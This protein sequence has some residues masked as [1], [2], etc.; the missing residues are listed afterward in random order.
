MDPAPPPMTDID[1]EEK[2][3]SFSSLE[4]HVQ[5]LLIVVGVVGLVVGLIGGFVA[6]FRV[7]QNLVETNEAKGNTITP[8]TA[9]SQRITGLGGVVTG[10]AADSIAITSSIG[11]RVKIVLLD[12]IGVKKA[13]KASL[14]DVTVGSAILQRGTTVANTDAAELIVLPGDSKFKGLEVTAVTDDKI[15][16]MHANSKLL[17]LNIKSTT[18]IYKLDASSATQI[19]KG[20]EVMANGLGVLGRDTFH[21]NEIIILAPGSAFAKR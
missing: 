13:V 5:R 1:E 15:T 6:G 11:F 2:P 4:L 19:E 18:A 9:P 3:N 17:T 10:T 21:A 14:D 16:V 12:T 20:F 8:K 7:E